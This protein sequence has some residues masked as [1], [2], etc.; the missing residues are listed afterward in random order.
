MTGKEMTENERQ[1]KYIEWCN[2]R[3]PAVRDVALRFKPWEL[4]RIKETG[5][6]CDI[7]SFDEHPGGAVTL[8][9][10]VPQ[11]GGATHLVFGY[12]PDDLELA[13]E[14]AEE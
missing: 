10:L 14:E 2:T 13:T 9:V 6:L 3:P 4:Y 1:E 8:K 7:Y 5:Q 11:F 12:Q